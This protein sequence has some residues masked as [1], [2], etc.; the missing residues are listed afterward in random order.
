MKRFISVFMCL[1][2]LFLFSCTEDG[3]HGETSTDRIESLN[4]P[5]TTVRVAS[6]KGPTS[7]GMVKLMKDN[8]DGKTANVYDFT[9]AGS[10][11]EIVP[12]LIK[13]EY[14]IAA[15]PAN[16]A[17]NLWNR[18]GGKVKILA[19][20]TLC[21]LYIV[22]KGTEVSSVSDLKGKTVYA[23]GKGSTPEYCLV[24]VL[25]SN[26]LAVGKD[27]TVEWKSEPAE[28]VSLLSSSGGVAM[29]P[30]PYVS[31]A[32]SKVEGLEVKLSMNDE[33][34]KIPS[35]GTFITGVFVVRKDFAEK[36]PD[37]VAS[38]A[39]EASASAG[40]V[41]TNVEEASVLSEK[42]SIV[43]SGIAKTAI[44]NCNI[45]YTDGEE[46]KQSLGLFFGT[47]YSISP[48][49]IG[50]KLPDMTLYYDK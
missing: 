29:L 17:C 48:E 16:L 33:W 9:V 2:L 25:E 44:P 1:I 36:H 12:G 39:S 27:V 49:S 10:A 43:N 13:G 30:E 50:G 5:K 4:G 24:H 42:Y 40:F 14:D 3:G 19:V 21:V 32:R 38:F 31:A 11:D 22:S 8:E 45:V 41:N 23:T 35:S 7:I 46:M 28:I 6:L 37:E 20:N 26:G 18:T 47:L 15:I 34:K